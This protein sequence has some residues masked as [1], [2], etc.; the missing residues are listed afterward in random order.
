M[1]VQTQLKVLSQ[2][3]SGFLDNS[4]ASAANAVKV[5]VSEFTCKERLEQERQTFFR[6]TPLL[7]GPST[8]LPTTTPTL[9]PMRLANRFCY[10]DANGKFR[11]F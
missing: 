5:P 10:R 3:S 7:L 4:S 11:A 6:D 9:P 2:L 8:D 1:D